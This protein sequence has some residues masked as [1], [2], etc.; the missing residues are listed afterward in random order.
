MRKAMPKTMWV[1]TID[2]DPV[3]GTNGYTRR[4][5]LRHFGV[6]EDKLCKGERPW[7]DYAR[8]GYAVK[9]LQLKALR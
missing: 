9:R 4:A 2:G 3:E 6:D 7:A 1:V 8:S 5:A